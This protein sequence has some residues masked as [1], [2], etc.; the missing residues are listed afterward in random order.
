MHGAMNP[1]Q[2]GLR[3]ALSLLALCL[4]AACSAAG[5]VAPKPGS[6]SAVAA[7]TGPAQAPAMSA[8]ALMAQVQQLIGQAPCDSDAQCRSLPMGARACGG[9]N[10]HL[11][12]SAPATDAL[13]LQ[14]AADRYTQQ[15][16]L[17]Q[18]RSGVVGI[19]VVELDPGAYCK[20][21]AAGAGRCTL[22][23]NSAGGAAVR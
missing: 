13:A 11:A 8:A 9:P 5:G 22:R 6:E 2:F 21:P 7:D 15:Q 10:L 1:F 18:Q 23:S 16:A 19:C 3:S 12:W 17:S 4:A 20:R 14:R